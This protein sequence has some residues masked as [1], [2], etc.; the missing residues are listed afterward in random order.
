MN[1]LLQRSLALLFLGLP[2]SQSLAADWWTISDQDFAKQYASQAV[3]STVKDQSTVAWMLFARINQRVPNPSSTPGASQTISQ[4]EAWP[5]N[6]DTFSPA[7]KLFDAKQK[8]RTRPHLQAPKT[9]KIAGKNLLMHFFAPPQGGGEEV[10]RNLDS[11]HYITGNGLQ[12]QF[13]VKKLLTSAN[14]KVD[15][16]VGAV[17][18]KAS[19]AQG[20]TE[21]AYQFTGDTGTY[22]LLGIHIMAKVQPA[23]ANQFT[24][25]DASWF[26]TT[27]E[28]QGNPGLK[29]AQSFLTYKDELPP[30]DALNLLTQAGLNT[31]AFANY[32]CNGTQIRY[33]DAKNPKI[34][35]GNTQMEPFN[36]TPTDASSPAQW[37]TWDISCHTCHGTASADPKKAQLFLP[38]TDFQINQGGGVIPPGPIAGYQSVDFVW[39]IPFNA[40]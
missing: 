34:I 4:W 23:P 2:I 39:S 29:N 27:F 9:A 40:Q 28:F 8:V 36:F 37:K 5:S 21:G 12:T 16:P 14:P 11:Y 30:A 10:T 17:E 13:G 24:S 7:V 19:W 22:S 15:L 1:S 18:I 32:K 20:A 35:L 26:W 3:S 6:A 25:E 31:T 38:F 33:S